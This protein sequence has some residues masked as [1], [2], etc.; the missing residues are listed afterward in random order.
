MMPVPF[1]GRD[2]PPL[3]LS[4]RPAAQCCG[5]VPRTISGRVDEGIRHPGWKE[6]R[7]CSTKRPFCYRPLTLK[8]LQER[9]TIVYLV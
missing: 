6:S 9:E 4:C 2:V 8:L 7:P 1:K 5:L 3:H